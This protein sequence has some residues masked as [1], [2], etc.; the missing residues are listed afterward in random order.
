MT[1]KA[2][3]L[4]TIPQDLT[5]LH[6]G[7]APDTAQTLIQLVNETTHQLDIMAMYW[8]L[9]PSAENK[10]VFDE[11][12]LE[13][14][15]ANYG[16][17][18]YD[19]LDNAAQRGVNIRIVQNGDWYS[20]EHRELDALVNNNPDNIEVFVVKMTRW[21]GTGVMHQKVWVFDQKIAYLGS[22]NMDWK[23][24]TQVKELGIVI[25][26]EATLIQDLGNYFDTWIELSQIETPETVEFFDER[27]Q[28]E[29]QVPAWSSDIA[30]SLSTPSPLKQAPSFNIE[31]PAEVSLN[32]E[33]GEAFITGAPIELCT[34]GRSFDEDGILYTMQDAQDSIS[35]SIMDFAP[36]SF[37]N[38]SNIWWSD[39]FN[40]IIQAVTTKNIHVRLLISYWASSRPIIDSYLRSLE[41][42]AKASKADLYATSGT[43]EIKR[44][45][46]PGWN[47]T[48][49]LQAKFPPFSRVNHTKYIVTDRRINIGTSNLTW[50][51]FYST[52]GTSFNSNHAGLV[53][54]LQ[55]IFDR[56]WHSQYARDFI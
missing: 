37:Y 54:G 15:G 20:G 46:I 48:S 11:E 18:L 41:T 23:A 17:M 7:T 22:T 25:D 44:F 55:S 3:F 30:P 24:L 33:Q 53:A 31:S 38:K 13:Q 2:Y 10:L 45:I 26:N 29:R 34:G 27:F 9:L 1:A 51:Y 5:D 36:T 32:Q 12:Q 8:E 35:L 6:S 28:V 21:Y 16:K 50:D 39:L 47:R 49:G 40:G 19:A 56:D 42:T 52:A 43:L 14:L 4:E